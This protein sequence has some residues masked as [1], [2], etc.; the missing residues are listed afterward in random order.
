VLG[1][2]IF[3]ELYSGDASFGQIYVELME[4]AKRDNYVLLNG[5]FFHGL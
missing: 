2:D 1:F 3:Y 4:G 5:Y